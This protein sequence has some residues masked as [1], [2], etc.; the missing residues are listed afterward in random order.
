MPLVSKWSKNTQTAVFNR[1]KEHLLKVHK[2]LKIDKCKVKYTNVHRLNMNLA[3]AKERDI[4]NN[5]LALNETK[6]NLKSIL[7]DAKFKIK[8]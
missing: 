2:A 1:A 5:F 3:P 4:L 6:N 7:I 8:V